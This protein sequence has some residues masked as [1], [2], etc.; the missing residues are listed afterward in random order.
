MSLD[1]T[2]PT[3][4]A[5]TISTIDLP[6]LEA[7]KQDFPPEWFQKFVIPDIKLLEG[8]K[9]MEKWDEAK[10]N[11]EW[12]PKAREEDQWARPWL[13][14]VE[15]IVHQLSIIAKDKRSEVQKY[16]DTNFES[17]S[18]D[19]QPVIGEEE[20]TAE[21]WKETAEMRR[22]ITA[23][24][25]RLTHP[26]IIRAAWEAF[27]VYPYYE[28]FPSKPTVSNLLTQAMH[29]KLELT[30]SLAREEDAKVAILRKEIEGC[31]SGALMLLRVLDALLSGVEPDIQN[32]RA[33]WV[34]SCGLRFGNVLASNAVPSMS[35]KSPKTSST[36][37][38]S[39]VSTESETWNDP[40]PIEEVVANDPRIETWLGK[41]EEPSNEQEVDMVLE[42]YSLEAATPPGVVLK[43][44]ED[45]EAA[46]SHE[47]LAKPILNSSRAASEQRSRAS[48]RPR[49]N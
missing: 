31:T 39:E 22:K 24:R 4:Q 1:R 35:S 46:E 26:A 23:Q 33:E 17:I 20:P 7:R 13:A 32:A 12:T 38:S 41:I 3:A 40:E 45:T 2:D 16:Y 18:L 8:M 14:E 48:K 37:S 36:E 29:A 30:L 15:H 44:L 47:E 21:E 9:V 49:H 43:R 42:E 10:K 19:K 34:W 6:G 25:N 11:N 5:L 27:L 28:S